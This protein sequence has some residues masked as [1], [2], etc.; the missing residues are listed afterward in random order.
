M[1]KKGWIILLVS[2]GVFAIVTTATII[3]GLSAAFDNTPYVH[4][5]TVLKLDLSGL[6]TEHFARDAFGREFEG[7]SM[8]LLDILK[9]FEMAKVDDRISGLYVRVSSLS[10]GWAKAQEIRHAIM[11]FRESGKFVHA[12]IEFCNEK[13]Y[14]VALASD[15]IYLQPQ[16]IC[17]LDG[18]ASEVPFYKRTLNKIGVEPQVSSIGKYKSG[19]DIF[20]RDS[21]TPE[22]REETEVLLED[23]FDTFVTAVCDVRGIEP[24]VLQALL[25]DGLYQS[26]EVAGHDLVDDIKYETDVIAGLKRKVYG[27]SADLQDR[28]LNMMNVERYAKVPF[29]EVGLSGENEIALIYAVGTILPGGSGYSPM[30]GRT[31][32]SASIQSL[33]AAAGE[34]AEIK[35]VVLRIDSPGGSGLASDEIWAEIE[36]L[37]KQ[38]PV[39]VSM[40]DVAASGGYLISTHADAVVAQPLSITGSIGVYSTLFDLSGTY[41]KLGVVWE[42]VKKGRYSDSF[43][44]KR[45]MTEVEWQ[46]LR[47]L[48]EDFYQFFVQK[49]AD[50]R[51][52]SWD[53]VHEVAQGRV[54][55]GERAFAHGLVDTLGGIETA[56]A[57]AKEKAGLDPSAFVNVVV[58]PRPR[59]FLESLISRLEVKASRLVLASREELSLIQ[60]LPEDAMMILRQL[61]ASAKVRNGEVMLLSP[62]IPSIE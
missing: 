40:S 34:N 28:H 38:K 29:S 56:L 58:Y 2:L 24:A 11:K 25:D 49:V 18:F 33:L 23:V 10:C 42:S 54:W 55:M 8:Q 27:E 21:M 13:G 41:D 45:P 35:A 39:V 7:A 53:E 14:F 44:D 52:K 57:V 51:G 20:M 48:N 15:S 19:G 30:A 43:T 31:L 1:K 26:E 36:E 16:S 61:A 59:S 46:R 3:I 62:F 4:R 37:R 22:H 50:G 12:Y 17:E 5:N 9:A 6:V 60:E 32:G 47:K